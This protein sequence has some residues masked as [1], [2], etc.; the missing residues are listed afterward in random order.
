M[1]TLIFCT[2]FSNTQE[3]WEGRFGKWL[4]GVKSCGITYDQILWPD[5]GSEVMPEGFDY[6]IIHSTTES[7]SAE[8]V[9]LSL[10]PNLGRPDIL[11]YPGWYRSFGAAIS[12]AKNHGFEKVIHI[13]SDVFIYSKELADSIN[14]QT[15]DW[16]AFWC[17][18]YHFPETA[19]QV[20]AGKESLDIAD[21]QLSQN[22][23]VWRNQVAEHWMKINVVDK[24]FKGDRYGEGLNEVPGDADY[25]CQIDESWATPRKKH[26]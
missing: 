21:E 22:Y 7:S 9:L 15:T 8:L 2:A 4:E 25:A 6:E 26:L 11:D 24:N 19:L 12:Y 5:D 18:K 17:A 10:L 23:D 1:K 20:I 13:E 16:R 14:E 3:R